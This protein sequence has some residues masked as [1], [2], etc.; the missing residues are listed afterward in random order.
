MTVEDANLLNGYDALEAFRRT[1]LS[2]R[3]VSEVTSNHTWTS[4]NASMVVS[5]EESQ[6]YVANYFSLAVTPNNTNT[7]T[8]S[9]PSIALPADRPKNFVSELHISVYSN[10]SMSVSARIAPSGESLPSWGATTTRPTAWE[11][12]RSNT[13]SVP[14]D[15]GYT[16]AKTSITFSG[17]DGQPFYIT[18]P[19]FS[20]D[21]FFRESG[22]V[23]VARRFMPSYYWDI[24]SQQENPSNP[25]YR[26]FDIFTRH[27]NETSVTYE[28]YFSF[29]PDERLATDV[30]GE[31]TLSTLVNPSVID[32]ANRSWLS[33]FTGAALRSNAD[34]IN[35]EYDVFTK[36]TNV[37]G[38]SVNAG[39]LWSVV[40]L[41][42]DMGELATNG[43]SSDD[44]LRDIVDQFVTSGSAV[45]WDMVKGSAGSNKTELTTITYTAATTSP[46][47]AYT[48]EGPFSLP[49]TDPVSLRQSDLHGIITAADDLSSSSLT[50]KSRFS[51]PVLKSR[52]EG[53]F[54]F[55]VAN[56]L[57]GEDT[58]RIYESLYDSPSSEF[59]YSVDANFSGYTVAGSTDDNYSTDCDALG[60]VVA[61][62]RISYTSGG[63]DTGILE[64]F[65][66]PDA[67]SVYGSPTTFSHSEDAGNSSLGFNHRVRVSYDGT[68]VGSM[69][70]VTNDLIRVYG[71]DPSTGNWAIRGSSITVDVSDFWLNS[72]GTKLLVI[73]TNN[74]V[75]FFEFD[76]TDG[77]AETRA[78][79]TPTW[80]VTG[81]NSSSARCS[82]NSDG[83]IIAIS[84][85]Y[86]TFN[87]FDDDGN[88]LSYASAGIVETYMWL[89]S[90]WIAIETPQIGVASDL[91]GIE[92]R[93]DSYGR[94]LAVGVPNYDSGVGCV[95]VLELLKFEP[96]DSFTTHVWNIKSS[97]YDANLSNFGHSFDMSDNGEVLFIRHHLASTTRATAYRYDSST[98]LYS[99][100]FHIEISD[101]SANDSTLQVAC[102]KAA[103]LWDHEEMSERVLGSSVFVSSEQPADP[104]VVG[105]KAVRVIFQDANGAVT[106]S[107]T[108]AGFDAALNSL[109]AGDKIF[110]GNS[111]TDGFGYFLEY[112]GTWSF[113]DP[114]GGVNYGYVID[115]KDRPTIAY[116]QSSSYPQ[117]DTFYDATTSVLSG[118]LDS[119]VG[120]FFAA[121]SASSLSP[122]FTSLSEQD[123]YMS[124]QFSNSYYGLKAGSRESMTEAAKLVL[125]ASKVVAVSPNYSGFRNRIHIRTLTSETPNIDSVTYASSDVLSVIAPTRPVGYYFTH[126]TV[127][128]LFFTLNNIGIGRLG[129]SVL[130]N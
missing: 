69:R 28:K 84:H 21:L 56:Q 67:D 27:A 1:D 23:N 117:T 126:E 39:A 6:R 15:A 47:L 46:A 81:P 2:V 108:N 41:H 53:N 77:W 44:T 82:M 10:S 7:V 107:S 87:G 29:E 16:H 34:A 111:L 104:Y 25:M 96:V 57:T 102:A 12:V 19:V 48:Y 11:V 49:V 26:L 40:D 42:A 95:F 78:Q 60:K 115:Y 90:A 97:I 51:D 18:M 14:T 128:K 101:A 124:W 4:N 120:T 43:I 8:V 55:S 127:D 61:T 36:E 62:G 24:D 33:Q 64:I 79:I 119:V 59:V 125:S 99:S 103:C 54:V 112:A 13:F 118:E 110:I 94:T 121:Q 72:D 58:T 83:S 32:P 22:F 86:A 30:D 66:K 113:G 80:T 105:Q 106:S 70:G 122:V 130:G 37:S 38:N 71:K 45:T 35:F 31:L 74:T 100:S 9:L 73:G 92:I 68:A 65:E 20:N 93:L 98:S 3:P 85:P 76:I 123:D 63:S 50:L 17:H 88:A 129:I 75:R 114:W 91:S 5:E 116:G 109:V 52:V 89:N